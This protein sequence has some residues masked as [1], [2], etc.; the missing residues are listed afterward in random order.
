[1]CIEAAETVTQ[2]IGD[3]FRFMQKIMKMD[4]LKGRYCV[5]VNFEGVE[6]GGYKATVCDSYPSF[7]AIPK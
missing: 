7:L 6:G 4:G 3:Y 1:M 5:K 2:D